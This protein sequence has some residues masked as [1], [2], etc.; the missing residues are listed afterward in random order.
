[1]YF[2]S[3]GGMRK[4]MPR[5]AVE[6]AAMEQRAVRQD[7]RQRGDIA[8]DPGECGIVGSILEVPHEGCGEMDGAAVVRIDVSRYAARSPRPAAASVSLVK[9]GLLGRWEPALFRLLLVGAVGG[10]GVHA[11]HAPDVHT[12]VGAVEVAHRWFVGG[13]CA[14]DVVQHLHHGQPRRVSQGCLDA[15]PRIGA[16]G[17][18]PILVC[19]VP[20]ARLSFAGFVTARLMI[21]LPTLTRCTRAS[22]S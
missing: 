19:L 10:Q 18:T 7:H 15:G 21:I 6:P 3:S 4:T 16:L 9:Q 11:G 1:M 12:H 17:C 5:V 14:V 2:I 13:G 22:M 8:A 20:L